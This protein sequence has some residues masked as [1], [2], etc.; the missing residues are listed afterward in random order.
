MVP[1]STLEMGGGPL[2]VAP[3]VSGARKHRR[4]MQPAGEGRPLPQN[5]I[6]D[7]TIKRENAAVRP[8]SVE[9]VEF[10][11]GT[12]P[13]TRVTTGAGSDGGGG[14]TPLCPTQTRGVELYKVILRCQQQLRLGQWPYPTLPGL[15][16]RSTL[17]ELLC[18]PLPG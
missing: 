5:N 4:G 2:P 8:L 16:P 15:L 7:L 13:Q 11:L 12:G 17:P 1:V 9:A 14:G 10:S 6:D 18:Q 3:Q